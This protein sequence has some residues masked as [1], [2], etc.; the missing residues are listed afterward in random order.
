MKFSQTTRGVLYMLVASLFF[1]LMSVF[2]KAL[3]GL[4]IAELIFFRAVIAAVLCLLALWRLRLSPWGND[5]P[6]LLM[7]GAAGV[8]SL[9]QGFWLLQ[10]I[11]LAAATTL[12]HLS[13]IFTTLLGVWLVRERVTLLQIGFFLLCFVGVV[14]IQGFDIRV[15][16]LDLLVGISASFCMGLAYSSV[17]R[18]GKSEHP[19]VI[20][21]YFPLVCLPLTAVAMLFDFVVPDPRQWL[22]LALLGLTAQAGQYCMTMSYH[23]AAIGKVAIVSYSEVIF[24]IMLGLALFGENF[25]LLTYL[26]MALVLVGVVCNLLWRHA[27]P[28]LLAAE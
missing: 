6:G 8:V 26:G 2:T 22:L 27:P 14:L 12:T 18:L 17:R 1:S 25:N 3:A 19:L 16:W 5:K 4:P 20:M 28:V 7:R 15:S 9:A 23:T 21:F 10:H 11:P 13:P 24:S